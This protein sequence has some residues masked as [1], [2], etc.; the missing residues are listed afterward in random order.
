MEKNTFDVLVAGAGPAGSTAAFLLARHGLRVAVIDRRRFPR[1]K[2]CGG[3]LTQKTL[4]VLE[5][6]FRTD[7]DAMRSAG[8]LHF[9][10]RRY[11]VAG[12]SRR[13][14]CGALDEPFHLVDRQA[15][16]HFWLGKALA[17]GA[18]FYPGSA[19]LRLDPRRGALRTADGEEYRAA[20]IVGA[21]GADSLAR[22][23][24]ER[25]G[26][27][28]TAKRF[29]T[30]VSLEVRVPRSPAAAGSDRPTLFYG[31]IPWG[32]AWSFPGG[33]HQ[34]LGM[35]G[36][37]KKSAHL[38]REAFGRFLRSLGRELPAGCRIESRPLPYGNY[39]RN[40]GAG[41]VLLTG[42]AAGMADPFLGEGIYYAHRSAQLAAEAVIATRDS[43]DSALGAYGDRYRRTLYP[44]LRYAR[45]GR[46][47][48]FS[49]PT[50]LY[51]PFL[52]G[53][54]RLMPNICEQTIQG[55]RSFRWLRP[56]SNPP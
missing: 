28:P 33:S 44:E 24:L 48:V 49:L 56:V 21:D 9:T 51:Y 27:L 30:A 5:A 7:A 2:L 15:Y 12:R 45:A 53:W 8:L 32:Y 42:D 16:D 52:A 23:T 55:R 40:P 17:A 43:P 37:R 39:L 10:T 6:V 13:S 14:V 29:E 26:L 18:L 41:R 1:P 34:L 46:Q 25:E 47:M 50:R 31:F 38:L 11:R 19:V 20:V 3:L 22:R 4:R 36:L 54:L 35:A